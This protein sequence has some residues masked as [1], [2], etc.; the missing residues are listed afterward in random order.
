MSVTTAPRFP[1]VH[2]PLVGEDGN[3]FAIIS[4]TVEA[5]RRAGVPADVRDEYRDAATSGDYDNVLATTLAWVSCDGRA[6]EPVETPA[7]DNLVGFRRTFMDA[8]EAV[9]AQGVRFAFETVSDCKCC[10]SK[11]DLGIDADDVTTPVAFVSEAPE[12][13]EWDDDGLPFV[14]RDISGECECDY[15]EQYDEETDETYFEDYECDLCSGARASVLFE[16]LDHVH[17]YHL[18]GTRAA[19]VVSETFR[20]HGLEVEWDGTEIQAVVV[21]V[22]R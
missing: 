7:S 11:V 22:P 19:Q 5:L 10:I 14:A 8:V 21:I 15:S 12:Q 17:I 20:D 9:Q 4:R 6:T 16:D 1:E 18:N 13:I 2:V 3:S